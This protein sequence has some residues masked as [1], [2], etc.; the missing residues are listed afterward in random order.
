MYRGEHRFVMAGA[1]GSPVLTLRLASQFPLSVF[2]LTLH[3]EK[4]NWN[5]PPM[6]LFFFFSPINCTTLFSNGELFPAMPTNL[7]RF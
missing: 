5:Q 6:H 4:R 2:T 7:E 3:N 1:A